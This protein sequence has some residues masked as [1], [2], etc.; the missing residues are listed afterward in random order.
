MLH[1][2]YIYV[3]SCLFTAVKYSPLTT[4]DF[5]SKI[6]K[7]KICSVLLYVLCLPKF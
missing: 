6:K 2:C 5:K 3:E 7:Y 4:F 1:I